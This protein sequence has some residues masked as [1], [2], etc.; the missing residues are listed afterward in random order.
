[1]SNLVI[2]ESPAKA[3]TIEKFLGKDFKVMSSM[4]HIRDLEGKGLCIDI[5]NNFLPEYAISKDKTVLYVNQD[6]DNIYDLEYFSITSKVNVEKALV[7][8]NVEIKFDKGRMFVTLN[9]DNFEEVFNELELEE[10]FI[11]FENWLNEKFGEG[12]DD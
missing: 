6:A 8:M 7:G 11:A 10:L 5:K 2:V 3:K 9:D 4:G 12:W 1:M